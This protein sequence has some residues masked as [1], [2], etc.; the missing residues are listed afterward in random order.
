[1]SLHSCDNP[2]CINPKHLWLGT[3]RSNILDA[4]AKGRL[5]MQKNPDRSY[6]ATPAGKAAKARGSAHWNAKL[7]EELVLW[8]RANWRPKHPELGLAALSRRLGIHKNTLSKVVTR[9]IWKCV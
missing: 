1:M 2:N 6:F 9:N 7:T 8:I 3:N 5:G 4:A